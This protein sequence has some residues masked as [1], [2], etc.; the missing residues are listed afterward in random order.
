MKCSVT[1]CDKE[2]LARGYCNTHYMRVRRTG[3]ADDPVK[4]IR[5]CSIEGCVEIHESRGLCKLHYGQLRRTQG[6]RSCTVEGCSRPHE[7]KGLCNRHYQRLRDT[8]SIELT[9]LVGELSPKWQGD[10]ITYAAAHRR[11]EAARGPASNYLCLICACPAQQW[12]YDH[13]D[14]DELFNPKGQPYSANIYFYEALCLKCHR[15]QDLRAA[16]AR[17]L[18]LT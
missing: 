8:G 11:L 15:H 1:L 3:T 4:V 5:L 7:A 12:S 13:T 18:Q 6:N 16:A 17:K 2:A 10:D 9:V 14:P